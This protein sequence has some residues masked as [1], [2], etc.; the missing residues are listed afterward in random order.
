MALYPGDWLEDLRWCCGQ[1]RSCVEEIEALRRELDLT[2]RAAQQSEEHL[3]DLVA[4]LESVAEAARPISLLVSDPDSPLRDDQR[5]K[6]LADAL[7]KLDEV[8]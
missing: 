8:K 7:A 5:V 6:G 3:T 2:H 4:R 1:L